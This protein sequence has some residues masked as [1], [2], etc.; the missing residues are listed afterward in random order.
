MS[1]PIKE[2][3]DGVVVEASARKQLEETASLPIV[4]PHLAVMPDVHWGAP[5]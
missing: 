4:W 5:G 1:A 2:W 3:T